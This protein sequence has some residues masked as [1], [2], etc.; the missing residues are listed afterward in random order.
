ML[1]R[2]QH[3]RS[4]ASIEYSRPM[5]LSLACVVRAYWAYSAYSMANG[6]RAS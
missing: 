5:K 6:K 1:R 3:P 4:G 2:A